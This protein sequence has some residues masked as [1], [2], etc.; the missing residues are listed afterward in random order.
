MYDV[1][2]FVYVSGFNSILL[3]GLVNLFS[4][5]LCEVSLWGKKFLPYLSPTKILDISTLVFHATIDKN[6][7]KIFKLPK[8]TQKLY[9]F[10]LNCVKIQSWQTNVKVKI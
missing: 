6:L 7:S 9:Y 10:S 4:L 5:Y 8:V 1:L 2:C 3:M